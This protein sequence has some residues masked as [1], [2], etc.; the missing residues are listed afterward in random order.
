MKLRDRA[1]VHGALK[2]R[3][4]A[5]LAQSIQSFATRQSTR[6]SV[7]QRPRALQAAA[8]TPWSRMYSPVAGMITSASPSLRLSA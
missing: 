8:V 1:G 4:A 5:T 6:G 2:L 3:V 7:P